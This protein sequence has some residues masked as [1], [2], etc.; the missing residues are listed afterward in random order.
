MASPI[1]SS[2]GEN[3]FVEISLKGKSLLFKYIGR[4]QEEV[5]RF[6]IEYHRKLRS[7]HLAVSVLDE[8]PGIGEVRKNA[9]LKYFKSVEGIKKA[10]LSEL[11]EAPD[12]N[13]R[14]ARSV[15]EYF[16]AE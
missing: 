9:L 16:H 6:A 11:E 4:I 10:S 15:W 3:D 13:R 14:A 8:I 7:K 1:G 5:H 2:G 12:M